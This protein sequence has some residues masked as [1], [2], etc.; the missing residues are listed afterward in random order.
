MCSN[1]YVSLVCLRACIVF[2]LVV[3][4]VSSL[5]LKDKTKTYMREGRKLPLGD[6]KKS[7]QI[8]FVDTTEI[9]YQMNV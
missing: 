8:V 1:N 2:V 9:R 5:A 4:V 7:T 3:V 6:N